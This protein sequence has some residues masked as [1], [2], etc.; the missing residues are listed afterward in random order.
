MSQEL[1]ILHALVSIPA[2]LMHLLRRPALHTVRV[3]SSR[4]PELAIL[5]NSIR[6]GHTWMYEAVNAFPFDTPKVSAQDPVL[7]TALLPRT[8]FFH[9]TTA[10][11]SMLIGLMCWSDYW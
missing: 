11:P 3:Q 9:T 6:P 2:T 4:A 10:P 5:D 1:V 7:V 8:H